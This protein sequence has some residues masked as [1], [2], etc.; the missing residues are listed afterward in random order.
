MGSFRLTLRETDRLGR[1]TIVET[2]RTISATD[3]Q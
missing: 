3:A 2:Q 1:R